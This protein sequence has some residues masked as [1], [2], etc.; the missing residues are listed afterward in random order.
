MNVTATRVALVTGG[1]R[2]L[3]ASIVGRL[4]E[5]GYAVAYTSR[6]I[7]EPSARDDDRDE[8]APRR[9]VMDL[10]DRQSVKTAVQ[11]VHQTLGPPQVL[12]NNGAI[13]SQGLFLT[14]RPEDMAEMVGANTTGTMYLTQLVAKLMTAAG[15]GSIVNISSVS[16]VRGY[17][18]TAAYGASKAAVDALAPALARE[19]GPFNIRVNS[20]SP[21]YFDSDLSAGVTDGNRNRIL[22]RTPLGRFATTT[23]LAEAAVFLAGEKA[24][25][26]T[27]QTLVIDG[28]I[29][30]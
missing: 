26:I 2:G 30:C 20:I 10:S 1:S 13:L 16:A 5:E 12:V 17:R 24:S 15:R 21:G 23:D 25:F 14:Q 28:G 8:R 18:G 22:K 19:L 9:F 29:T 4:L 27:G 3:G 7:E 6:T 11:Q